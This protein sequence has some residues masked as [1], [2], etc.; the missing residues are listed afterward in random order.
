MFICA[1]VFLDLEKDNGIQQD[2]ACEKGNLKFF[3]KYV[4]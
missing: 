3:F 4:L 2:V 1:S